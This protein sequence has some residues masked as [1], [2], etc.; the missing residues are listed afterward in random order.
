MLK[1]S[2]L[3]KKFTNFTH[4]HKHVGR[5]QIYISVPFRKCIAR[6]LKIC[7]KMMLGKSWLSKNKNKPLHHKE[8]HEIHTSQRHKETFNQI[9]CYIYVLFSYEDN[10]D[11]KS[12]IKI[13]YVER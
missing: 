11:V 8:I 13:Q 1:I 3:F 6:K 4:K 9:S 12:F 7:D 10:F 5:F 2:L